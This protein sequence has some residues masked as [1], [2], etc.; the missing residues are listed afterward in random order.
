VPAETLALAGE[1]EIDVNV[2]AGGVPVV[3]FETPEH[4]VLDIKSASE[5]HTTTQTS[6]ERRVEAF[7]ESAAPTEN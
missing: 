7:M 1:T 3:E 6:R 2:F 4:P 5:E